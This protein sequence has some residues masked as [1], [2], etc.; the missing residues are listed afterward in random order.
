MREAKACSSPSAIASLKVSVAPRPAAGVTAAR[1]SVSD[2]LP[3]VAG[4]ARTGV[5]TAK[6]A[7]RTGTK[8]CK[9]PTHGRIFLRPPYASKCRIIPHFPT[10]PDRTEFLIHCNRMLV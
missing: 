6:T 8:R 9:E 3:V 7:H 4:C 1:A 10:R 5:E 2:E